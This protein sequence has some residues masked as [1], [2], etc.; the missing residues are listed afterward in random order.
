MPCSWMRPYEA[1]GVACVER[2]R[3]PIQA[4]PAE[5]VNVRLLQNRERLNGISMRD[6]ASPLSYGLHP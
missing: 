1:G 5:R 4:A 2:I 3:N 6:T